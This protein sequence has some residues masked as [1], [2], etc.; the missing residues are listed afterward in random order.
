MPAIS[1]ELAGIRVLEAAGS[2]STAAAGRL[3]ARLG[4][5]V[6]RVEQRRDWHAGLGRYLNG[7]KLPV[8]LVANEA[9]DLQLRRLAEGV[10]LVLVDEEFDRGWDWAGDDGVVVRVAHFGPGPRAS[11]PSTSLTRF[12]AGGQAAVLPAGDTDETH[13]PV[14]AGVLSGELAAGAAISF[15]ALM[16]VL[17]SLRTGRSAVVDFSEHEY[18]ACG[19]KGFLHYPLALGKVMDRAAQALP[20]R[21]VF[22]CVDGAIMILVVEPHHW[23]A[24]VEVVGHEEWRTAS[25]LENPTER[26]ARR[27]ELAEVIEAWT[28]RHRRHDVFRTCQAVGLPASPVIDPAD[29]PDVDYFS[30]TG[31]LDRDDSLEPTLSLPTVPWRRVEAT[32]GR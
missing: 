3:L 13:P 2:V 8:S 7:L 26:A 30:T 29:I 23:K 12:H 32:V 24:L 4:A 21:G 16:H 19:M 20:M 25:E 9:A 14:R 28:R 1:N 15:A 6:T 10:D 5:S 31:F 22:S 27:D 18:A 17:D 11:Q